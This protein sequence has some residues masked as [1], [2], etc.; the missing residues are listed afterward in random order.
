MR[1]KR[2]ADLPMVNKME[3]TGLRYKQNP[4]DSATSPQT[5]RYLLTTQD[6]AS[7]GD[8]VEEAEAHL[9]LCLEQAIFSTLGEHL[10]LVP[11]TS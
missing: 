8:M 6:L 1:Q 10:A 5:A 9:V 3:M 11:E 7:L 2:S 4:P